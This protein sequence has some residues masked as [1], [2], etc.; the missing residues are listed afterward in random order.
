MFNADKLKAVEKGINLRIKQNM[1]ITHES[2]WFEERMKYEYTLWSISKGVVYIRIN[3]NIYKAEQG[4]IILFRPGI[5]FVCY[6]DKNGC[7]FMFEQII[8][9]IDNNDFFKKINFIGILKN[10]YMGNECASFC[11]EMREIISKTAGISLDAYALIFPYIIKIIE[12]ILKGDIT[13]FSNL[14]LNPESDMWKAMSY[15]S[16]HFNE[17]ISVKQIADKVGLSE[18]YFIKTFK[19]ELGIS[20]H[21][22]QIQCRMRYAEHLLVN[23]ELQIHEIAENLCYSDIYSFSKAF[24][25]S[26]LISPQTFREQYRENP[27]FCV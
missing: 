25:K 4:D 11:K 1:F 3:D 23:S 27:R 2:L 16:E 26:H 8:L 17:D 13:E 22:Y 14:P 6:T 20:P 12:H 5:S 18:K 15:I 10:E 21:Q 24:K 9:E 19:S 7:E